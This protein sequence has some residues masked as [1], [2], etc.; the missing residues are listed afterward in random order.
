M[1]NWKDFLYD[2]Y[3]GDVSDF[4]YFDTERF[5]KDGEE[6]W[7]LFSRELDVE[8]GTDRQGNSR[9]SSKQFFKWLASRKISPKKIVT[10]YT[11]GFVRC[12]NHNYKSKWIYRTCIYRYKF[13]SSLANRQ[14]RLEPLEES[15]EFS[16][17]N[18]SY[19]LST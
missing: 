9:W 19:V 14:N 4:L 18:S 1:E 5:E 13:I 17:L 3:R 10:F 12:L 15:Q 7:N 6:K 16:E 11:L 8:T 2:A